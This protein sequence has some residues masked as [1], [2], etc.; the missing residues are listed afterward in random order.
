MANTPF[1][2]QP[3]RLRGDPQADQR[4]SNDW[5]W[6]FFRSLTIDDAVLV[7]SIEYADP[8]TFNPASLPVP[9]ATTVAQAQQTANSAYG[10]AG[11][12]RA[13]AITF[14]GASNAIVVTLT[15]AQPDATYHVVATPVATTGSPAAGSDQVASIAKTTTGF[16][17]TTKAAPGVGASVTFDW[18]AMRNT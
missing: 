9:T 15:R 2:P 4:A 3:P 16:T 6:R 11:G 14:A 8:G 17:V 10:I 12:L 5:A 13:G 1:L 18:I 7:R